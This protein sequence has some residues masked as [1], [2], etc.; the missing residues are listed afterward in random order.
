[1]RNLERE[2][3]HRIPGDSAAEGIEPWSV[4]VVTVLI[5]LAPSEDAAFD[6]H[7]AP[8]QS[9][10]CDSECDM[11]RV[12]P[13][14]VDRC[15]RIVHCR[16]LVLERVLSECRLAMITVILICANFVGEFLG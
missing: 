10:G 1:M 2:V 3:G 11:R 13:M 4:E 15:I 8:L 5:R 16:Q 14:M 7:A 6:L 12:L 9:C